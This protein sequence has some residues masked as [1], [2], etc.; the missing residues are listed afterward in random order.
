M[1]RLETVRSKPRT[2]ITARKKRVKC[3]LVNTGS[4]K[5]VLF[6]ATLQKIGINV[7]ELMPRYTD[8]VVFSG[9]SSRLLGEITLPITFR[10]V[11]KH[12][13]FLITDTACNTSDHF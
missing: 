10:G 9:D 8:L 13:T 7:A 4:S 5:N 6:L 1:A 11:T 12:T 2:P 3:L